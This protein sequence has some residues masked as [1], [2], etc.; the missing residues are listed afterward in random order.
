MKPEPAYTEE[1]RSNQLEGTL[2][3]K[4]VFAADGTV[5]NIKVASGLLDGLEDQATEA[6]KELNL[7]R[8]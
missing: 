2:L 4:A 8:P 6:A 3:L 5:T 1:A 7:S